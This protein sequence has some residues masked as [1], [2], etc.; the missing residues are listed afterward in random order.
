MRTN[1]FYDSL[2]F[3]IGDTP[4]HDSLG[5]PKYLLVLFYAVLLIAGIAIAVRT[6]ADN[7]AQRTARNAWIWL[8][9]TLVGTMWFQGSLWKL[10]LPVAG[11]F[12]Y[13]TA[14]LAENS[15]IPAH[16][17]L[18]RDV[19]LPHIDILDPLVYAA[20]TVMAMS[21]MLGFAVPAAGLLAIVFTLNLWV[22]LYHNNAEWPWEYVFIIIAHGF[23]MLDHAGRS[24]GLDAIAARTGWWV[25]APL[26][27]RAWR[28]AS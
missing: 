3:L 13:W 6:W 25:R 21:L 5:W 27:L 19:L 23:F 20:E 18:V 26:A 7:P 4:D 2:L 10:P 9:R 12:Q 17:A 14:Q 15:F 8:F 11:G 22:G 1:P 24:L 16:A 28:L